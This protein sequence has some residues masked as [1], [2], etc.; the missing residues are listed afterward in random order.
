MLLR[1]E[2]SLTASSLPNKGL[3]DCGKI[4]QYFRKRDILTI[5]YSRKHSSR[6]WRLEDVLKMSFAFTFRR[7]LQDIFKS[8]S[9]RPINSSNKDVWLT[10]CLDIFKISSKRL[11][12]ILQRR[13]QDVFR[14]RFQDKLQRGLSSEKFL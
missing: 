8:Y 12:D 3:R 14:R 5:Y 1:F 13:P 9:W 11:Q 2:K 4:Y 7:H 6:W 10:S